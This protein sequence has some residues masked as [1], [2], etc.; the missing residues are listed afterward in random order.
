VL[1]FGEIFRR[2]T[3]IEEELDL[4]ERT[5]DEIRF[6][7]YVRQPLF[8]TIN[9]LLAGRKYALGKGPTFRERIRFLIV[10]FLRFWKN[11]IF[12]GKKDILFI[13]SPRRILR[14]DGYWWD[15][16]TD[17]IMEDLNLSYVA[18][19]HNLQLKHQSPPKTSNLWYFDFQHSLIYIAE[20]MRIFQVSLNDDER[21]LLR[22]IQVRIAKSFGLN[23]DVKKI[24]L[25]HLG[26][27]RIRIPYFRFVLK[28]IRPKAIVLLTSYG[29]EDL[30]E[31]AKSLDIPVIELQHGVIHRYHSGYSFPG[32]KHRKKSFPDW[33]FTFG[34]YWSKSVE[35]T[36]DDKHVI[37]TGFPYIDAEKRTFSNLKKKKQILVL[38][39]WT[40]GKDLSKF[41]ADLSKVRS[42]NYNIIY[43]LHP[44]E[45][46]D[47]EQK[48]PWL[49]DSNIEVIHDSKKSLY[50][51]FAESEIQ[52]G[53]YSTAI[54]E[55]LAFGLKTYIVDLHGVEYT[56]Q[57]VKEGVATKVSSVEEL[58]C[59][60]KNDEK[61]VKFDSERFFRKG[62]KE[63]IT[64]LLVDIVSAKKN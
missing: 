12:A 13:S 64:S 39:Q 9:D 10:S 43:K 2:I 6:W 14:K 4:F 45:F 34:D 62:A 51:L 19:E 27:R 59:N 5:I 55:G 3:V 44:L 60:L 29:K 21:A 53:V 56:E 57:L 18:I 22:E 31:P 26:Y 7:E 48:Y 41:S 35:Y 33:L 54:F 49:V 40:I 1:S 37:S 50:R 24:V 46:E 42:L 15:I 20:K 11:P 32:K 28:R 8:V 17:Y 61:S 58:V 63:R 38:S 25:R 23:I 16:I 30:I 36:I 47:W 52:I